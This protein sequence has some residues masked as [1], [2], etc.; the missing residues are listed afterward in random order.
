MAFLDIDTNLDLR[1]RR[2]K[3]V[4]NI[5]GSEIRVS[6]TDIY[7]QFNLN[8]LEMRE[9]QVHIASKRKAGSGSLSKYRQIT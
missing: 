1:I 4:R 9:R 3:T 7:F 6:A 2:F 5:Y 8:L